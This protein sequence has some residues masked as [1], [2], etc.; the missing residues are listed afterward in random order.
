MKRIALFLIFTFVIMSAIYNVNAH[1]FRRAGHPIS[2]ISMFKFRSWKAKAGSSEAK[3]S[4][5]AFPVYIHYP[6]SNQLTLQVTESISFSSLDNLGFGVNGLSDAKIK[7]SYL[8]MDDSALLAAGLGLPLGK[9]ALNSAQFAVAQ[10]LNTEGLDFAVSRLGEGIT[11][12]LAAATAREV[13]SVVVGAGAGYLLKG[14]YETIAGSKTKYSPGNEFNLTGGLDWKGEQVILRTDVIYIL[15]SADKIDDKINPKAKTFKQGNQLSAEMKL[16]YRS[17][18]TLMSLSIRE[19]V[20]GK[21]EQPNQSGELQPE[22]KKSQGNRLN[23][24]FIFGYDVSEPT[25]LSGTLSINKIGKNGY[26]SNDTII[27]TLGAGMRYA[28][29]DFIL[30]TG[31]NFSMGRRDNGNIKI[32]GYGVDLGLNYRF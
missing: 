23:L 4:Q 7:A 25:T 2:T 15:Y 26:D 16:T 18:P 14:A 10:A 3:I 20:V 24:D 28:P 32:S 27:F 22:P 21:R 29:G 12:N 13:G 31:S 8:V 9:N 5:W 30:N 11:L 1:V 17:Q 6:V 19:T